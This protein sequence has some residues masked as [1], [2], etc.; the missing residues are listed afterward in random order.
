VTVRF[1][2]LGIEF[3]FVN[4]LVD[5]QAG[6][7]RLRNKPALRI[8]KIVNV[9]VDNLRVWEPRPR[10]PQLSTTSD[11]DRRGAVKAALTTNAGPWPDLYEPL[12]E[13]DPTFVEAWR[14]LI[15]L[16]ARDGGLDP[17]TRELICVAVCASA[18]H[19]HEPG[20]RMH[21]RNALALGAERAE[22]LEV[23]EQVTVLGVHTCTMAM[24]MLAE[25]TASGRSS[26]DLTEREEEVRERF[27]QG[28]GFW[29]DFFEDMVR[30]DAGFVDAYRRFS[31]A[32]R[33]RGTIAPKVRELIYLAID[34]NVTHLY[35][36]GTRLHVRNALR[37][38]ATEGELL[39][40][41]RTVVRI[42][43]HSCTMALPHLL[44]LTE[45]S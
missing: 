1:P 8:R 34:A 4:T 29:P 10:R 14:K 5:S 28:R 11:R 3:H 33:R 24:P 22:L 25:Q 27:Q 44:E 35:E 2:S 23:L 41:L 20:L 12:L 15:E 36:E 21:V 19:L 31:T 40:V 16:A 43:L 39:D 9:K 26:R 17:K 45:Q 30:L 38:G 6:I 7:V 37:E 32:S 42:G 13:A 18:S